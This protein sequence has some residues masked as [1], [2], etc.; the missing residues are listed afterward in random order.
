MYKEMRM[1]CSLLDGKPNENTVGFVGALI[2]NTSS[3]DGDIYKC[4]ASSNGKYTWKLISSGNA[5]VTSEN[6]KNAL[7]YTPADKED[8]TFL[9]AAIADKLA[10]N[11]GAA[12]VGKILVVGTDGNLTLT[13]MPEGGASGDVIGTLDGSNNI[14][15][16]GDIAEGTYPLKWL[17]KDGTYVDA[18]TLTVI[19]AQEPEVTK[20]NFCVPDGDGWI[21][22]GRCGSDGTD[23]TDNAGY[24]LTNYIPAINGDVVYVENFHINT[25][26]I[27]TQYCGMYKADADKTPIKGFIMTDTD[28]AG[29]CKDIDLSGDIKQFTI[30]NANSGFVRIVGALTSGKAKSDI[31]INVKRN[32]EWL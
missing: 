8:V 32:G 29:Y 2:M 21:D 11:Q 17:L 28:A 5:D 27:K 30:D 20:T 3:A 25:T 10:I 26:E 18:G 16:S 23:R 4:V 1:P 19:L 24:Y 15:L 9:S 22:G 31:V 13:D 7:G 6:I 12:N 14:L